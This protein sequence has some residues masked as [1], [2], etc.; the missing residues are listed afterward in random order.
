M[1]SSHLGILGCYLVMTI[2]VNLGVIPSQQTAEQV[3]LISFA[4]GRFPISTDAYSVFN[5]AMTTLILLEI[6]QIPQARLGNFMF[7]DKFTNY[8]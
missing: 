3:T 6:N 1:T 7:S 5:Q 4:H 8:M 2:I